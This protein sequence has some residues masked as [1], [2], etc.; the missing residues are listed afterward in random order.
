MRKTTDQ[1]AK[2]LRKISWSVSVSL[3]L[4]SVSCRGVTS[5]IWP[6]QQPDSFACLGSTDTLCQSSQRRHYSFTSQNERT[7]RCVFLS[8]LHVLSLWSVYFTLNFFYLNHLTP[9]PAHFGFYLK[10]KL[11]WLSTSFETKPWGNIKLPLWRAP[12]PQSLQ[13]HENNR[14]LSSSESQ[15]SPENHVSS[16][17]ILL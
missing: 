5:A 1:Q 10:G 2:G 3:L 8:N 17:E 15:V 6:L 9:N 12:P 16:C 11:Y 13:K 4:V 14:S 7:W